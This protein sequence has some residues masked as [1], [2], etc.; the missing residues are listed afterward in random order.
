MI[1]DVTMTN[2]KKSVD[3]SMKNRFVHLRGLM[4]IN[5]YRSLDDSVGSKTAK[6]ML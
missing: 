2:L 3:V 1:G 6:Q 5:N 4:G